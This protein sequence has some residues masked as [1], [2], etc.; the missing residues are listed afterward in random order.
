MKK[1]F[2]IPFF[3]IFCFIVQVL[4]TGYSNEKIFNNFV[5]N[6]NPD[7]KI[8][9]PIFNKGFL[10][11]QAS[12][13]IEDKRNLGLSFKFHFVFNNNYFSN[14][15]V[16]GTLSNPFKFL[17]EGLKNQQ[18]AQFSIK[19]EQND[20]NLS[21]QFQDI[22][23][24]NEGGD[25]LLKNASIEILMDRD[26]KAKNILL[27]IDKIELA[28]FYTKFSMQNF[29][30]KQNFDY[31]ILL[32]SL[33]HLKEG[34]EEISFNSFALNNNK[35]DSFY[36]KNTFHFNDK[37]KLKIHFQGKAHNI[38]LDT[39]SKLYQN[40]DFDKIEFDIIWDEITKNSYNKFDIDSLMKE[41][42]NLKIIDLIVYKNKQNIDI[43]GSAF[44][45]E[46]NN[47][48][49]IQIFSTEEPD[50]IF[51]WGKFFGGLNQYFTKNEDK[52]IMNFNYDSNA[53][54]QLKINGNQFSHIDLN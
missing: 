44:V 27:N 31:P 7:Y 4:Y 26:L 51:S 50:K 3:I 36:N 2:L 33:M 19:P 52:F 40:I 12:F 13:I 18:L 21:I 45:S 47:K 46:K 5:E 9:N 30:Y 41:G 1:L 15:V 34:L 53:T 10:H 22:N 37:N 54:P 8:L 29:I 49:L 20:F 38:T 17:D 24:S 39:N 28:Q 16:Q 32:S 6:Q 14:Y 23:L 43:N 42:L 11:S 25:T 48:A 35:I